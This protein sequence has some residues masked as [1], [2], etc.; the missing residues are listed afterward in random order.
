MNKNRFQLSQDWFHLDVRE[1][2]VPKMM[3]LLWA[4]TLNSGWYTLLPA[5][6]SLWH[7]SPTESKSLGLLPFAFISSSVWSWIWCSG[8]DLISGLALMFLIQAITRDLLFSKNPTPKHCDKLSPLIKV[9]ALVHSTKSW[10]LIVVAC[11]SFYFS[12]K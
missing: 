10:F 12:L 5:N 1:K 7:T 11:F 2:Y 3:S 8:S 6:G 9:K 4:H